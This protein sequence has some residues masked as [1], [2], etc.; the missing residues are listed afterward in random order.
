[1]FTLGAAPANNLCNGCFKYEF[2]GHAVYDTGDPALVSI[3]NSAGGPNN[4]N[5]VGIRS[6]VT[7]KV[8]NPTPREIKKISLDLRSVGVLDTGA[9]CTYDL[10]LN[11]IDYPFEWTQT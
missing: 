5:G 1:V 7:I 11:Q 9:S 2:C 4:E 10:T 3:P 8:T 6:D